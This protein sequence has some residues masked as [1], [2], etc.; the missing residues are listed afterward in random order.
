MNCG[1]PLCYCEECFPAD[2]PKD[3]QNPETPNPKDN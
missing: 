2:P 1:S 3:D